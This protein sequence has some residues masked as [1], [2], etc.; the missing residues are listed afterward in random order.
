VFQAGNGSLRGYWPAVAQEAE[1]P[2]ARKPGQPLSGDMNTP[3][4]IGLIAGV[5]CGLASAFSNR[6]WGTILACLPV[7][8]WFVFFAVALHDGLSRGETSTLCYALFGIVVGVFIGQIFD[9]R[10]RRHES[11]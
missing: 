4:L 9:R 10:R 7:A 5:A 6:V 3:V 8:V 2:L 11:R 1:V